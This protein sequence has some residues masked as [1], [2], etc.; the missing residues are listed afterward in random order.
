[1]TPHSSVSSARFRALLTLCVCAALIVSGPAG[2]A[3][4]RV[5]WNDNSI[6]KVV[7][8][9]ADWFEA[10][11]D[12]RAASDPKLLVLPRGLSKS[13]AMNGTEVVVTQNP[14]K[15]TSLYGSVVV[16]NYNAYVMDGMNETGLAAH[17]LA[18]GVTK[19]GDRDVSR[20]GI[21]MNL[22]VQYL[23]DN[24]ATVAQALALLPQIQPVVVG[25][26][27]YATGLSFSIEDA[28]GDSA[29]VEYIDGVAQISHGAG[30][31][32][33]ANTKLTEAKV[34]LDAYNFNFTNT[35]RSV[36]V[37][38]NTSSVDRF[39][40]ASYYRGLLDHVAPRNALEA[41]AAVMS[42]MRNVSDPIGAPGDVA[43]VVHETDWRTVYD[44]TS[45]A[46]VF[47]NPR[48]LTTLTTD[49]RRLNFAA[50]T[51][52]R[53]VD[54]LEPN[55]PDDITGRYQPTG[56]P[57]PAVGGAPLT[58]QGVI[59]FSRLAQGETSIFSI[60]ADGQGETRLTQAPPSRMDL[61]STWSADGSWVAFT[62]LSSDRSRIATMRADGSARTN[63]TTNGAYY[64]LVPSISPDGSR[65]AYTSDR[66]GNYEVYT[67]AA[68][69][70]DERRITHSDP[71]VTFVG[72]KYSP[73][74]TKL[75]VAM[76]ESTNTNQDLYILNADGTGTP[77]RLTT[78]VNNAEG[79][80]WSPDGTRIVF[81]NM[82]N[83]VGQIFVINTNGTGLKQ[84]TTN[85]ANTPPLDIGDFFPSIRGDVTPAW[86]PDG[87]WIA[88]ASDRTGNFEV[89]IVRTN[90][91]SL[92]Q[93][94]YTTNNELSLGWRPLPGLTVETAGYPVMANN[95]T[96]VF[97]ATRS[98]SASAAQVYTLR[99]A[100]STVISDIVVTKSGA[101]SSHFLLTA[102]A[103][104][105]LAPGQTTAFSAIFS[106]SSAGEKNALLSIASNHTNNSPFNVN[107]SGL[108]LG[109]NADTDSDGL[110]DAAEFSMSA[111]GFDWQSNQPTLVTTLYSNANVAQ[112]FTQ[113][114]FNGNR[115]AGQQDVIANPM[116]FGLYDSNSIM[117]LRMGGLMLE[118]QGT[119]GI[120]VF[121]TQTTTDLA[122]QP[123]TNNGTPITNT[124]PM[125]GN[126]GFLRIQ[127]K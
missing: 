68:D 88:F 45:R 122:T 73:D 119:D 29:V 10:E 54:P 52:V 77:Q 2:H 30:F 100:G 85:S 56:L 9:T 23:L 28:T 12:P 112:L 84:I 42:V 101:D 60:R 71:L 127:A 75:L 69:G 108:G 27:G 118:K 106:P 105:S 126:K 104:I 48:M 79:R 57:V 83:G 36:P 61:H 92:S 95:D 113:S 22:V 46:F 6:A 81:N 47:E 3:C 111:L 34:L 66:S 90:G 8:R 62:E 63:I 39:I 32:V 21:N 43:G 89:N 1:M 115:T 82:V 24:A 121:Q 18:L 125:P 109:E 33:T 116:A 41:R 25:I 67:I 80:A 38:G 72:P 110:N 93:V 15:W 97:H 102:P 14:A 103:T 99:N 70:S 40:R 31:C 59:S 120:V 98:G 50:G 91:S 7:G 74:G 16:A 13:G 20:A 17:A 49:L 19:Y 65:I 26:D 86:S 11:T 35:T 51:G 117:D 124:V 4:T 87:E 114:Q 53:I 58:D 94:T 123:F 107:I 5:F 44:L 96:N 37:P 78:G 55:L 64:D 76:R